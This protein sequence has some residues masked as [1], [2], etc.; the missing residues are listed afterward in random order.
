MTKFALT[1]IVLNFLA[2]NVSASEIEI[3]Y[4]VGKY[5]ITNFDIEKEIKY[6]TALNNK[7]SELENRQILDIATESLIREKIKYIELKKYY[8]FEGKM[9]ISLKYILI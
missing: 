4:K 9:T 2:F 5:I 7:L 6:L 3:K 8:E 1:L